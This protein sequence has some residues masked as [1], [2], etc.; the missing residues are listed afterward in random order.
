M[1]YVGNYF[2]LHFYL[3]I[4]LVQFKARDFTLITPETYNYHC[5]LLDGPLC[6]KDSITY[7]V[8]YSSTLNN[9]DNFHVVTQLPQD[10]THVLLGVVPYELKLMLTCFVVD[11]KYLT[12]VQLHIFAFNFLIAAQMWNL[13][14][15][16]PLMIGDKIPYDD[17]NWECFLFLLDILQFC[18]ARV[19]SRAHAGI[20]EYMV[21]FPRQIKR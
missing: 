12:S 8:Q 2:A 16:L 10:I 9:I 15:N 18:T 6:R 1:Y 11:K 3:N 5:S 14:I 4:F 20:L 13:A 7:G 17:E 21:H 19:A